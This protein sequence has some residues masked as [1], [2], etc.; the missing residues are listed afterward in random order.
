MIFPYPLSNARDLSRVRIRHQNRNVN[1]CT[2]RQVVGI[3]TEAQNG[4][5]FLIVDSDG[6]RLEYPNISFENVA[7]FILGYEDK[8]PFFYNIAY[9]AECILKLLPADVL[10]NYRANR[11]LEFE[12]SD[13]LVKYIDRKQLTVRR[14]NHS[15]SCYDIAQYYD[16]KRL[17]VAYSE[18][19]ES[20][21]DPEYLALKEKRDRFTIRNFLRHKKLLRRYC[22]QDSV[23]TKALAENWLDLFHR[24][25][26]FY[27]ARWVSSGYL[28][29]KV[30]ISNGI[31]IPYFNDI[32]YEIQELAWQAFYGGRFELIQKGFIGSCYLYDINSAY[33]FALTRLPDLTKGSWIGD[34]TVHDEAALGFF[35]I[36][37][38]VEDSVKVAPFPFRTRSNTIIY[39]VG[40][41]ET[42]VTL[43]ELITTE[44]DNRISYD[45]V[46]AWQFIPA[47]STFPMRK[48]ILSNYR[49]R[50]MLKKRSDPLERAIKLILNSIYGKMAQRVNGVMGNLFSPVIASYIT[51]FTRAQLFSFMREHSLERDIVA[52]ATDSMACRSKID[53]LDSKRLGEMKLDKQSDVD[54]TI[55]LSNGFYRFNGIWKQ[56]GVGY[57]REKKATIEHLDTRIGQDGQLY[58]AVR[59][60]RTTHIK[61]AIMYNKLKS[62]G[63]IDQYERKIGLNSDKKRFWIADLVSLTDGSYCDSVPLNIDE[64]GQIVADLSEI[65]WIGED[66]AKY[67]PE[68]DL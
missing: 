40:K 16:N 1:S 60:T 15:A 14:G 41:F 20:H 31:E 12:Y 65:A 61:T 46:D 42:F 35:R 51:G 29:E 56:R 48:F 64:F 22:L 17:D 7:K 49:K 11:K 55:F 6:N 50:L 45:I 27:P 34:N 9:D 52:F 28:A 10:G 26:R 32:P 8:W 24:Q 58:I 2:R 18:N 62:V 36:R 67:E 63:K 66:E 54:D 23:M 30:L 5:I 68:S 43:D 38:Y 53:G 39:P 33:P 3:D 44:D 25:F 13:Y 21:L 59:T 57:D 19:I 4:D 47:G 37:A